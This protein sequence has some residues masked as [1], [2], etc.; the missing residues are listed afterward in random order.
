[1]A[2]NE[3]TALVLGA[4]GGIG[5][6]AAAALAGRGWKVRALAR[7]I[8]RASRG[9]QAQ[10]RPALEWTAGDAMNGDSVTA[11]AEGVSLI[12]H[13]VNPPGYRNWHRL[14]LPMLE[15]TLAAAR[16]S[17]ARI[18]LPGTVYNFGPD[19]YARERA[20]AEDAPQRPD[21]RKG[22]IRVRMEARL[23]QAAQEEG[24]RS[25]V[26]RAGDFFGPHAGNNW[27]SQ[28]LVQP[29]RVPRTLRLP[30]DAGVGHQW[31]YL[32]DMAE[33]LVRLAE[34]EAELPDFERFHM[35]GHWDADGLR[36]AEAIRNVLRT[37]APRIARFPWWAL[38]L[39]QPVMPLAR[40]LLEMRYLWRVP[41][42]LS[43]ARLRAFL[44]EEPHTPLAV[45]VERTLAGQ[46]C[47][48]GAAGAAARHWAAG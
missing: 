11:A 29:G 27:F 35:D 31:A 12:V 47:L 9:W 33:T 46:G 44:G 3:R 5:G 26:L 28:A 6:E 20:V 41:L 24:I 34:R 23:A 45:A 17:G 22:A 48:P 43:N 39:A 2:G 21:T 14:V 19:V 7:D 38:R 13:A 4:T 1:M 37:G 32:P 30:G 25:L 10:G 42:R 18:V 16:A 8:D 15:S 40:E 36:L